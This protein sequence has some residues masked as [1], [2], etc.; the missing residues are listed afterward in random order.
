MPRAIDPHIL[1]GYV[2]SFSY[3]SIFSEDVGFCS[4]HCCIY[5]C[6]F[7]QKNTRK[8]SL[9]ALTP[10]IQILAFYVPPFKYRTLI[11]TPLILAFI[12]ITIWSAWASRNVEFQSLLMIQWPWYLATLEKLL[13][14]SPEQDFWRVDR[15]KG[16]AASMAMGLSKLQWSTALRFN[17]RGVG[18]NYQVKNV[19]HSTAPQTK[20]R[21]VLYQLGVYV[22][23]YLILDILSMYS[24][25]N[26]YH[27]P[28]VDLASLTIR[29]PS[30]FRSFMNAFYAGAN[31]YHSIELS[32]TQGSILAV[33]LGFSQP[34]VS[35]ARRP[36]QALIVT[37]FIRIGHQSL[38]RSGM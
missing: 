36:H 1:R 29:D 9:H 4:A 33:L 24:S 28:D 17:L 18:W 15:S 19:P 13:F 22:K 37:N 25:R 10:L 34:K 32:Y 21:F 27:S 11:F 6:H 7:L 31:V 2:D 12:C 26:F 16:E 5:R 38:V 8:M 14:A 23:T 20:W 3:S 35:S 30:W